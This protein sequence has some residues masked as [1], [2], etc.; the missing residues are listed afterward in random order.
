MTLEDRISQLFTEHME[1]IQQSYEELPAG[2]LTA[3]ELMAHCLLSDGKVL[4]CGNGGSAT[5]AQ[6]FASKMINRFERE[7]PSLPVCCINSDVATM[8]AIAA[9]ATYNEVFSKQIRALGQE[10]DILL[11]ISSDGA[12]ANMVQAIQA[13]HDRG[14]MVMALTGRDGGD[15]ARLL[16]GEDIEIRVP[17]DKLTR[18][19]ELHLF[20]LHAICDLIDLQIF[21]I[22]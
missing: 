3:S 20:T 13:A 11:A 17:A 10:R 14:M 21:G 16:H 19:Q 5:L 9:D 4:T 2:I 8:T 18:V 1:T 15:C 6:H 12:A 22:D 7:R